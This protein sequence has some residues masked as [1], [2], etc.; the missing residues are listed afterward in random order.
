MRISLNTGGTKRMAEREKPDWQEQGLCK[1]ATK[2]F[3][4]EGSNTE[5]QRAKL[6]CHSCPVEATC[7]EWALRNHEKFGVWGGTS[8][9]ER[10][11]L[12]RLRRHRK[13]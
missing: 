7:L 5:V 6:I 10:R 13:V 4:P 9:R 11:R 8:E 2:T 12:W 3:Y 1:G